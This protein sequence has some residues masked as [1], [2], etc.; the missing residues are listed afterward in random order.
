[1]DLPSFKKYFFALL[2]LVFTFPAHAIME[3]GASASYRRSQFDSNKDNYQDMVSYTGSLSYYFWELSALEFNYTFGRATTSTKL[4]SEARQIVQTKFQMYGVDLVYSFAGRDAA[5]QP[6]AKIG[7]ARID[8][9]ILR[10]VEGL[11]TTKIDEVNG[12]VPTGGVGFKVK[13]TQ[14]FSFKVGLDAWTDPIDDND[15]DQDQPALD[16]AVRAGFSWFL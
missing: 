10:E 4:G 7:L 5:F 8:K 6:Y 16:Y 2:I 13:L 11:G 1:M 14:T 9:D 15:D 3:L 12:W